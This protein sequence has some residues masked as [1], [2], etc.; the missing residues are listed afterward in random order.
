VA[1][2]R[3]EEVDPTPADVQ[4]AMHDVVARCIHGIDLNPMAAEL[5]R[6]SL[7]LEALTPGRPLTFLD[8]HVKV[9]N[10]L[11]G[12]TPALVAKGIPDEAYRPITG[13]DPKIA[14]GLRDRNQAKRDGQGDLFGAAELDVSNAVL[15]DQ[16]AQLTPPRGAS[17]AEVHAAARRLAALRSDPAYARAR[18]VA[19][20]W[21][22]AFVQEKTAGGVGITHDTL[23]AIQQ[24]TAPA[25]TLAAVER[26]AARHGF[27]HWHLEFPHVYPVP[28]HPAGTATGWTGGFACIVGNP[29][30]ER[31]KLQEK[32]FFAARA[33]EVAEA[34]NA[35]ARKKLIAV[36][37]GTNPE[38][39]DEWQSAV[40]RSEGES[41]FLRLSGRY[42][43]TGTGDI[44]TY[45]VFAETFAAAVAVDGR[46]G[47]VTPTGLATDATTSQF[48][49]SLLGGRRLAAFYDFENEAKIFPGVHNQFRFAV[50]VA[51]GGEAVRRT[52]LA[53]YTRHI[54]EVRSRRFA[55]DPAEVLLLNPNTGTL[56]V[57]RSRTDAEITLGVY[58][59]HPVLLRDGDPAGNPWGLRFGTMF[60]M[61]N[62]S[63]RFQSSRELERDGAVFDGW[64]Y[65]RGSTCWLPLY[66]AKLVGHYDHRLSTYAN[67]TQAQLNKGTLP[68]LT[69]AEHADPYREPLAR[70]WVA[71]ADVDD[72]LRGRWDRDWLFGWRGIGRASDVRTFAPCAIPRAAVSGKF[73]LGYPANPT[74]APL[75]QVVM[76][77]HILDYVAR[78][79]ISG[80]DLA[81]FL[82]RQIALP[83]PKVFGDAPSWL[84]TSLGAWMRARVLELSYTSHRIAGYARDVL[85]LDPDAD[86]GPPFRW[87]PARRELLR[88][89]LDAAMFHLY[90][91]A[92]DEVDHVLHSFQVLRRYEQRDHGEFRTRRLVLEIYDAM[93]RA[94]DT[95]HPYRTVLDPEPGRGP[96][97]PP[98]R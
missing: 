47:V 51:T 73:P 94:A 96:R 97:H 21:C 69:D 3:T 36:L 39:W 72:A 71:E 31:V 11:L 41:G 17:L 89:E 1:T 6:V 38:L 32:E 7:W 24:G 57:F 16:Q 90:G 86:P 98:A 4:E 56:P 95:G 62:D 83:V 79:K 55:L 75:L 60:H 76:S 8:A 15:R 20:A 54:A 65:V 77:S 92:R 43:L 78:Q 87:D 28:D 9:G 44:N 23:T 68:R 63:G 12:A 5:A 61:A 80:T 13:D 22:A 35:A 14:R 34:A 49:A 2:A 30:W 50:T 84:G 45:S 58:R 10:A 70:Y 37:P 53:F 52:R 40:R 91:L 29:P 59:R 82:V 67:A 64:A 19:D 66:E 27:F 46:A 26:L 93:T 33:P 48:F 81:F 25:E 85:R 74:D 18:A 88:A 42:P